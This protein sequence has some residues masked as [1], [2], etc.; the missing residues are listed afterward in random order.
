MI[1]PRSETRS[2][3]NKVGK[4]PAAK[5]KNK[6]FLNNKDML[7]QWKLS[8]ETGSMNQV[9]SNMIMTLTKRYSSAVRFNVC[10]T[11]RDDMES[12]ALMTVSKVWRGFDP[13]KSKNPFAYFTQ[14]IKR[15][16]YQYQNIERNHR[17]IGNALNIECGNDPSHAF[18][19]EYE[20]RDYDPH[21]V[22]G[23]VTTTYGDNYDKDQHDAD[24]IAF[25]EVPVYGR[26]PKSAKPKKIDDDL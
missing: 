15:A 25:S 24:I 26:V 17:N 18:M 6:N 20:F 11:F 8:N 14:V 23:E 2:V 9:F 16:F 13:E 22:G 4:Q 3:L 5:K 12:Y 1:E 21:K 7:H 10:D 19:V